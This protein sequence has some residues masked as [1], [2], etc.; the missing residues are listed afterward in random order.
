M[1]DAVYSAELRQ[2]VTATSTTRSTISLAFGMPMR[3]STVW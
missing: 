3:S 1:R 2:L